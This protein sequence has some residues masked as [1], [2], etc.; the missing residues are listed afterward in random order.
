MRRRTTRPRSRGP[1]TGRP[2]TSGGH[3]SKPHASGGGTIQRRWHR[4]PAAKWRGRLGESGQAAPAT[5]AQA[6][7]A[8][9]R[10]EADSR[11]G[12]SRCRASKGLF[13]SIRRRL[14]GP[15]PLSD[16]RAVRGPARA[17]RPGRGSPPPA[18]GTQGPARR[19]W[20]RN[21]RMWTR[22]PETRAR[23]GPEERSA[24]PGS[25]I[26]GPLGRPG[27]G[28]PLRERAVRHPFPGATAPVGRSPAFPSGS[29]WGVAGKGSGMTAPM[30]LARPERQA[31]AG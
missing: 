7:S 18:S 3:Y 29:S 20:P 16:A 27:P 6:P 5:P 31:S 11:C 23:R 13:G 26:P 19:A 15:R 21:A 8:A 4:V 17:W 24:R 9:R 25:A 10:H 22:K 2:P 14:M 12:R 30:I 28:H 1:R